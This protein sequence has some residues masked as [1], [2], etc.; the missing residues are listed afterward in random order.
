MFLYKSLEQNPYLPYV[1]VQ[2]EA[3]AIQVSL[4]DSRNRFEY[5][6]LFINTDFVIIIDVVKN[7]RV[8]MKHNFA[9]F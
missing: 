5:T 4:T 1:C 3:R 9:H 6:F 8:A 2:Q 7:A